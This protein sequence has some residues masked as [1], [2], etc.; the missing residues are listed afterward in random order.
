MERLIW[1]ATVLFLSLICIL[2]S[3][4]YGS[5]ALLLCSFVVFCLS[6]VKSKGIV[7]IKIER[8]HVQWLL[9]GL[10]ALISSLWAWLPSEAFSKGITVL[11]LLVCMSLMYVHY[12]NETD[13]WLLYDAIRWS[14][15]VVCIYMFVTEGAS[16]ILSVLIS[17]K[18]MVI[19]FANINT[20][21]MVVAFS[22]IITL[23]EVLYRKKRVLTMLLCI[24]CFIVIAVL[25]TRKA[26]MTVI[27][28]MA[29]LLLLRRR[30]QNVSKT[31][32]R[33]ITVGA[34]VCA[35]AWLISSL[36]MFSGISERM[37]GFIAFLTGEGE[38]DNSTYMRNLYIKL[39]MEQFVENPI[40]GIG[41]GSS[42]E[43]LA[44]NYQKAAYLHN[45]FAELLCCGGII[46]FVI[47]YSMFGS[48]LWRFFKNRNHANPIVK[49]GLTMALIFVMMDMARV[50]YYSKPTVFYTMVFFLSLKNMNNTAVNDEAD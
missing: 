7:G 18:L 39:G 43:L 10:Y 42:K 26:L 9:F 4:A 29:L 2:D 5:L 46:G 30:G 24:P 33:L 27:I 37:D 25:G 17:G 47:Y 23:Y 1:L 31:V 36:P 12:Q 15:F 35:V 32:T 22:V 19:D 13:T 38:M 49:L 34:V 16:M 11:E 8:F 28:G 40:L 48:L 20:V 44:Q 6:C 41:I 45:N 21:S 14:G 3:N 50:T